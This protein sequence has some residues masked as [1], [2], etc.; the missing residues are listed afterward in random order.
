MDIEKVKIELEQL[1]TKAS[2]GVKEVKDL[3]SKKADQDS[4]A[5]AMSKL[6]QVSEKVIAIET[7]EGKGITEYAKEMQDQVND[8]TAQIAEMKNKT[9]KTKS[10]DEKIFDLAKDEKFKQSLKRKDGS[11]F[12]LKVDTDDFTADTGTSKLEQL[13]FPEVSKLP[14]RENPIY[15][16]INKGTIGDGLNAVTYYEEDDRTD[17]AA[18]TAEGSSYSASSVTFVKKF[19]PI[20]KVGHYIPVTDEALSDSTFLESE[21]ND[22]LFNGVARERE[23]TLLTGNGTNIYHGLINTDSQL[24][25]DFNATTAGLANEVDYPT[26]FDVLKAS[27]LQVYR[28]DTSD[29]NK[30]GFNANQAMMNPV[31]IV[32]M[33]LSKDQEGRYIIPAFAT[34][35]NQ[36]VSGLLVTESFDIPEGYILIGDFS[37]AKAYVKR[38]IVIETSANVDDNFLKDTMVMKASMRMAFFVPSQLR[39]A[40]VYTRID[41]ALSAIQKSVG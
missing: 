22:L 30:R 28:G 19:A 39:Y 32:K 6:D 41:T 33:D 20:Y 13:L 2:E 35:M 27:K 7:L 18:K 34:N 10:L 12:L 36:N 23:N 1:A 14:W 11:E 31:D 8:L 3:L 16:S 29:T 26:I 38:E 37:K 4:L 21:L 40:F 15:A 9:G 17:S 24:A 25:K 5:R